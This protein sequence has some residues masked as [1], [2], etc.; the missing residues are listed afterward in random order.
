MS[1]RKK[2][3]LIITILAIYLIFIPFIALS[4]TEKTAVPSTLASETIA[5]QLGWVDNPASDCGG[6]YL[7]QPFV[8]S[9]E[10]EKDN[11][12]TVTSGGGLLSQRTTSLLEDKVTITR[13]GQQM[14][15]NKA[16]LYRDP[17][18]GKLSTIDMIGNVRLR[19]PN[20]LIIGKKGRY[21]FETK[22]KS[23]IDILYRT[24]I[25]TNKII[26]PHL[27]PKDIQNERK[28]TGLTAW[29]GAYEF[30]QTHPKIYELSRASYST[31]SPVNPTWQVKASHIVLNKNT[32]RGYA[33]HARVLVKNIPVLYIPYINFS[34]D[35][36]RKTGFLWPTLGGSNKW[37]PY[38][39]APFYWNL[40]PNYDMILTPGILTKRGVQL[41]DNFRYLTSTSEGNIN[42]SILP[43]D[44]AF[45]DFQSSAKHNPQYTNPVDTPTQ[46]ASVTQAE[47]NRLL[48]ASDT[49]K[50][51]LW[52]ND[53]RFNEHWSSHIDY[54][55]ASDDY[56]LRD[57]GRS[58]NEISANQLLQEGD[59]Y[60]KGQN[61]N[62]TGRIQAYQTL[63]PINE[64]P[65]LNQYR[66]FPQLILNGDYPDQ[67]YGLEYFI[68]NEITHFDIL[69][70]PGSP[71]N[72]PIGNRLH[73]QP[74]ISLPLYWSSFYINPRLQLALTDY[75]LHQTA[76]TGTPISK[77]RA[78]PILDIASGLALSRNTTLFHHAFQQTLEPQLYYTYIPYRNQ[79]SIP[80]F[81]TTVNTLTYD[82]L[83]NYNRFT[84][85]DR[86]GDANQIGLGV[87]TRL[88]DEES[89]Y[90]KVRLGVGDI[91][92]F[93]KR[94]VTL[95]NDNS[96]SDNPSN[97]SNSY[98]LS[99]IS[100]VLNYHVN[101]SWSVNVNS[102]WNP[103]SKQ[104]D[105]T[106]LALQYFPDSAHLF[107]F[108]YTYA[109]SGDILSGITTTN[110]SNNLKVTDVSAT[111]PLFQSVSAVG[112]WSQN[113]NHEHLQNLLYGLQYETCCWAVRLVGGRAFIGFNTDNNNRP[114][115]NNEFYVQFSL[116]GLGDI[117]T[118][119][120]SGLLSGISGYNS[121]FGQEIY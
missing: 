87:T 121:Q 23:L 83:F 19:E 90:E 30:S 13:Q 75:N 24:S 33:T 116:K 113:W 101:K 53:S 38:V 66:R 10:A 20:S 107:N 72:L 5:K 17:T 49:R 105:N 58:L 15:A 56:Y 42:F 102:I 67:P 77:H 8:Y 110:A 26:A 9:T 34:I 111:W 84:G 76:D 99:P 3:T 92:Y 78:L 119:N 117:G 14:T 65:V 114:Q 60:Y 86:I 27:S 85:I 69:N 103:I 63:H 80:V 55:Y 1:V 108:A 100:G 52:R 47:L 88:I 61:W 6:Y 2:S 79:S 29:G 51:L 120:P 12:V 48:H 62:F 41:S 59:L 64:S 104:L 93:A 44:K 18:T 89:G 22:S 7:E 95:C 82:Q 71:A 70:T 68:N 37:G 115:Y 39:L 35:K 98:S 81:D 40:A 28:V 46:T 118:G 11:A 94:R 96:C 57:F 4:A 73:T 50:G 91:I 54:N 109:R 106:T 32:G 25:H 97:P 31:C 36:Q 112:R 45:H 43:S 16:Y 74:G 21:R